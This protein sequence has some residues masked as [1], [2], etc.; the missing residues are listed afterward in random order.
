MYAMCN[1]L[2][3]P[4]TILDRGSSRRIKIMRLG[5][6]TVTTQPANISLIDRREMLRFRVRGFPGTGHQCRIVVNAGGLTR[7]VHI[8]LLLLI[9]LHRIFRRLGGSIY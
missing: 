1:A 9:G 3:A 2:W 7:L 4:R 5:I 6:V 8:S